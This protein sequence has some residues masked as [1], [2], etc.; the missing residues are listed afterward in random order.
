M[1]LLYF[2]LGIVFV[3]F[4]LPL[5]DVVLSWIGVGIEAKKADLN[6]IINDSNIKI[7]QAITSAAEA[8]IPKTRT[9]GF[10]APAEE[11]E[12]TEDEDE[13]DDL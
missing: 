9:I 12:S 6:E 11:Y 2:I 3:Q 8:N 10:T 4:I 13:A 5:L 1:A 7:K